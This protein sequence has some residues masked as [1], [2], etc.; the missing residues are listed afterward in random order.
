MQMYEEILVKDE[1]MIVNFGLDYAIAELAGALL[2]KPAE[3]PR[4]QH[5]D[6]V[7]R[8]AWKLVVWCNTAKADL[9]QYKIEL[10]RRRQIGSTIDPA[11]AETTFWWADMNDPYNILERHHEGQSGRECFAR[12]P[13]GEW[14]HFHDMPEATRKALWQR[15]QRK[16]V[17]PYGLHPGDDIINKPPLPGQK[18][19]K[20]RRDEHRR[21]V[22]RT[23]KE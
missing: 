21:I 13:S 1:D 16:L 2:G 5:D 22:T 19:L 9:E 11:T 18:S 7:Y 8:A 20:S 23:I 12:N 15:D 17:F 10:E 3:E 4:V 14:V 6:S